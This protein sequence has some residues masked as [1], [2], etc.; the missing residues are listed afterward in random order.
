MPNTSHYNFEQL[1]E[2]YFLHSFT[3]DQKNAMDVFMRFF[4][5]ENQFCLY[6]LHIH[7]KI[8]NLVLG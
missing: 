7:S 1:V 4:N 3:E 6:I 8:V 2:S 5:S